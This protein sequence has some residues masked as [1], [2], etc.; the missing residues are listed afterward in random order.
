MAVYKIF[1]EKDT[2]LY[3]DYNTLNAGLDPILELSKKTS[4]NYASQS[5]AARI[6]I[7]FANEDM[8]DVVNTYITTASY[9][10]SLK[11]YLA[12]AT[13][14][15][16]DVTVETLIVSGSWDMGTG[17]FGDVPIPTDGASW[18]YMKSG[19][20]NPWKIAMFPVGVTASYTEENRGGGNWYT[21]SSSTQSF[22][23]YTP[24][25]LNLDVT[26]MVKSFLS[27][28]VANSGF[29]IK[30]SGSLEFDPDY[31]FTLNYFSRDTNTIYPPVLE[32]KWDD[33]KYNTSG[34]TYSGVGGPDIRISLANN[35]GEFNQ[36]EIHRFRLNVRD[37]FPVRTYATSSIFTTQK[38]LPSASYYAI[39]DVKSDTTVVDFDNSFTKISAD[40]NGNYFDIYMYGLEPERYYK[41]LIKTVISGST[42]VFDDQ[43][44]FKVTE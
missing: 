8:N 28:S 7:K 10:A 18:K 38:F 22:G 37:Q 34:S 12:D 3:S 6:L 5:T 14:L 26:S 2:T 9:S 19:G 40:T 39:K 13:G 31:N 33:S 15:P 43:Y 24:K 16:T 20:N 29:I 1:A 36:Y 30:V 17:H 23:V 41:L 4:L 21:G 32:F 44:F 42:L 27:G 25:D 11:L 35:K